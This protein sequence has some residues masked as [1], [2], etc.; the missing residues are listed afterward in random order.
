MTGRDSTSDEPQKVDAAFLPLLR[1][2]IH[3]VRQPLAVILALAGAAK[4]GEVDAN[5]RAQMAEIERQVDEVSQLLRALADRIES[6]TVRLDDVAAAVV[7]TARLSFGGEI[8][9]ALEQA[10]IES[11]DSVWWFVI[12]ELV[13]IACRSAGDDGC[14]DVSV[15]PAGSHVLVTAS[16]TGE[17]RFDRPDGRRLLGPEL[18]TNAIMRYG[19]QLSVDATEDGRTRL[20]VSVPRQRARP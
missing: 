3:D 10:S 7:N 2:L 19:G 12:A 4:R 8:T 14:V 16:M 1:T 11:D 17:A 6:P 9:A 5:V 18:I 13:E 20:S 15:A